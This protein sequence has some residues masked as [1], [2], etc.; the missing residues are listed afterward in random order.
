MSATENAMKKVPKECRG[1]LETI[2]FLV[3]SSK[4]YQN[5]KA[6][7][8]YDFKLRGYLHC[9]ND[10]GY[11]DLR[12][13]RLIRAWLIAGHTFCKEESNEVCNGDNHDKPL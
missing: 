5:E 11:V 3:F 12:D 13:V 1:T 7:E 4:E 8:E 6:M 9:L 2:G 10:L